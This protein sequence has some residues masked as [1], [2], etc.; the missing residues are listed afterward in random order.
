MIAV[1]DLAATYDMC[2]DNE[3]GH[4][5][6]ETNVQWAED[7]EEGIRPCRAES[8]ISIIEKMLGNS[9]FAYTISLDK[10]MNSQLR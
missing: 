8:D 10:D 6:S 7:D 4:D 3:T 1:E 9:T 5:Q 2:E